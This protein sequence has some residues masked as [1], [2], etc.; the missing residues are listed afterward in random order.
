M[1]ILQVFPYLFSNDVALIVLD[2]YFCEIS[3]THACKVNITLIGD[4]SHATDHSKSRTGFVSDAAC[5]GLT[6]CIRN[7]IA[8]IFSYTA[9]AIYCEFFLVSSSHVLLVSVSE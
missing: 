5:Q 1:V 2:F 9:T 7:L 4:H 3:T 8:I 6:I